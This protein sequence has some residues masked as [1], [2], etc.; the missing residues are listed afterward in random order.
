MPLRIAPPNAL[1]DSFRRNPL[2]HRAYHDRSANRPENSLAAIR[3]AC[4]AGYGIEIDLQP[5]AD[6]V[7]MVFHDYDLKRLTGQPGRIRGRTAR[8][9]S[10]L[11]LLGGAETIPTLSA[12]LGTIAGRVPLLIELKDQDG[13]MGPNVGSLEQ[14]VAAVL[15]NYNGPV[16]VMSFNPYAVAAF[17]RYA[18]AI[19]RGLTT[20][21]YHDADWPL[22]SAKTRARLRDVPDANAVGASFVSHDARDLGSPRV[23]ALKA[24]GLTVL[25]WT[26]R[27]PEAEAKARTV[28]DNVTFEGYPASTA[29]PPGP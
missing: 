4:D 10:A 20:S 6:N 26:V 12:A 27:S 7:P 19:P 11:H 21:A 15:A 16:A 29:F 23:S 24:Q 5:S 18:P 8:E 3:A 9:L 1:P 22:L 14:A 17:A 25:C 28:A 13:D 2:A